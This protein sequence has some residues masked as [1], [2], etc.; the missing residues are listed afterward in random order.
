MCFYFCTLWL[1]NLIFFLFN[2]LNFFKIIFHCSGRSYAIGK[3]QARPIGSFELVSFLLISHWKEEGRKF[4]IYS[5]KSNY[6]YL[7]INTNFQTVA[8]R[9]WWCCCWWWWWWWWWWKIQEKRNFFNY[10]WTWNGY[11]EKEF[12]SNWRWRTSSAPGK[13]WCNISSLFWLSIF[14]HLYIFLKQKLIGYWLFF[15]GCIKL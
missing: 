15:P 7:Y 12:W 13:L 2:L 3:F 11:F 5:I 8:K 6:F 9:N 1:I 10:C 4:S 14:L